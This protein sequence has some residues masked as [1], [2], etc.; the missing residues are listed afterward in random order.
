MYDGYAGIVNPTHIPPDMDGP[1]FVKYAQDFYNA[2]AGYPAT[3]VPNTAIFSATELANINKGTYTNWIDLIKRNGF[4]SNHNLSITGGDDKTSYFIAGGYQLYQGTT[5][6]E[7]TKK[8]TFKAGLDKTI[9]NTFKFGASVYAT[10]ANIHPGSGEV[11]RSAY[12]L[13]PTGSAYNA[14]GSKRFFVYEGESQI[15]NPLF[16]F[17]NEIRQQQYLHVLPNVYG[18]ATIIKGLKVRSSFSPDITFQRQGQYDDTYT[19][20]QAGTKPASAA[21]SSNQWVNYTLDNLITY[22]RDMGRHKFDLALGN[23]FEYHQQDFSSI[24]VQGLPYRSLWYNMGTATTVTI[25]GVAIAPVGPTVSSGYSK[26]NIVSY[27]GRLNYSFNNRYLF[28]ATMRADGNSVFAPGHKWG[29]FPSGAVAWKISEENF[30][31]NI[32]AINVLKLRLSFGKSGNASSTGPY[33]TQS[34]VYQ[35]PYDFNGIAAS[36]FA[37][38]FGN[39]NLTWEKTKEFNAGI[40]MEILKSRISLQLDFYRKTSSGSILGQQIPPA[41]G[42]SSTTTN[43]GSVRNQGIEVSLNTINFKTSRFS[44]TTNFNFAVNKNKLLSLYGD[45][46]DDVGNARFLGQKVRVVYGY[47]ILGVW[48]TSEA[49]Q[50]AVFGQKPGQYKIENINKDNKIDASDRQILGSNIPNWFGGL[51][52]NMSFAN[53]DFS[54]TVYTRQGT[55]ENSVFLEQVMN[56]DQGRARFGAFDRSYWT[57]TNPSNKWANTAIETDGTRRTIAQYQNSSYTK[58]SNITLGYTLPKHLIDKLGIKM[59]RVYANAFNPFIFSKF[60]GWDPENPDGNSFLNQDFR[61]RTFMLGVNLTL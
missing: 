24:S 33:I 42:Y 2:L 25:N 32:R 27:Y 20:Q 52:N 49:A 13:R 17:D 39:Q 12:R 43:L 34:T 21:S 11:F 9:N 30:F 55:F 8:Y 5:K 37:P 44:W 28:T 16:D 60:I 53:F 40:D 26:Q 15:T 48:Q 46:K 1:T 58:I 41:N 36:G 56:G 45:G 57:P 31:R 50:A 54:F 61:T 51:T 35:T 38:N 7:N 19:K 10:F 23:T 18:E 6:I 29:Y 4:Q 14:D 47:K 59:L 22:G 3:P